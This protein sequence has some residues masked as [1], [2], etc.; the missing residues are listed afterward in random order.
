VKCLDARS[1][2][3][4]S[5]RLIWALPDTEGETD[6]I[7]LP[8]P[9]RDAD[10]FGRAPAFDCSAG[11]VA[12]IGGTNA[13]FGWVSADG[14]T[15]THVRTLSSAHFAGPAEAAQAYLAELA[16][17]LGLD[18]QA[19]RAGAFAVATAVGAD[20]VAFTNSHWAFSRAAAQAAL[21]LEELLLVNDFEALALSL[22]RLQHQQ[23]QAIRRA[24]AARHSSD[25]SNSPNAATGQGTPNSCSGSLAVI[26]PGTGLGVAGLVRTRHGWVAVPG[27][28]GHATLSATDAFDAE[29]LAA[30]RQQFA[31]VSAERLLSGI[32]LPV[33][34]AAVG[35]VLG[36]PGQ[37]L[38][39]ESIVERG[40]ARSDA[41][42]SQTV[43]SFCALLGSFAGNVAL[44]LGARGGVYIGGGIVPRLGARFMASKFRERFEAK[45]RFAPYL[46]AVPT[47]L[48]TDTLAA[49][50]GAALAL[51]QREPPR[52]AQ[53][54]A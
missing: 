40:L 9:S 37:P 45:G 4:F 36:Q 30:A 41:V 3:T 17:T 32:G 49:L 47:Y 43:D 13:R 2:A 10:I 1:T 44:M 15:V 16:Q 53:A 11:L 8:N 28:G 50:S 18:Y 52:P 35:V 34:H 51:E 25:L 39:S 26:G 42:C 27:E 5:A 23:V 14:A 46:R 31:H 21:G 48:I 24:D 33:L 29:V 6:L 7:H 22:P 12:D 38:S 19:P 20:R 54:T